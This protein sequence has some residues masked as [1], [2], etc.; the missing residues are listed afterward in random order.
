MNIPFNDCINSKDKS[1]CK[2]DHEA[3]LLWGIIK[4]KQTFAFPMFLL[5]LLGVVY[6]E[7]M[8]I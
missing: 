7:N 8:T 3:F 4:Q 6:T 2:A 1:D 5:C